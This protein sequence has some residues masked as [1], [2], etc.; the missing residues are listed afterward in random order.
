MATKATAK[1]VV[2]PEDD[3]GQRR[4]RRRRR[5][6][7]RPTRGGRPAAGPATR[8]TAAA[9][10]PPAA[11]SQ[12]RPTAPTPS[13]SSAM[14]GSRATA[15]PKSTAKRS[16]EMAPSR[17]GWRRMKRRPSSASWTPARAARRPRSSMPPPSRPRRS[18]SGRMRI[19]GARPRQ[20]T[21]SEHGHG[22]EGQRRVD[23]VEDAAEH[24]AD[25]ERRLPG[26]RV[27]GAPARAGPR[28][29]DDVG[30]QRPGGGRDERPGDRRTTTTR[31]KIG[32]HRASAP[33]RRRR[34]APTATAASTSAPPTA[35][36]PRSN[37]SATGPVTSTSSSGREELGEAE[38]PEV[39]LAARSGRTPACPGR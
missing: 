29:G 28:G 39:E 13:R 25:D 31:A 10:M 26:G 15:P 1:L 9:P 35:D 32:R 7:V 11:R 20:R 2:T 22:D 30:G 33:S 19:D 12:P 4:T 6:G 23:G 21:E 24:R 16:R 37:R 3:G 34:P 38:Q 27:A 5:A 14:A 18:S 8:V 17:I 36:P